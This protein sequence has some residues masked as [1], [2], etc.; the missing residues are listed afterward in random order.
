MQSI[1]SSRSK[2]EKASNNLRK[3]SSISLGDYTQNT[4]SNMINVRG[5][6]FMT[7]LSQKVQSNRGG[8]N[9]KILYE[10]TYKMAPNT[11]FPA[12]KIKEVVEGIL[13]RELKDIPYEA[14][15][16][17]Q[18]TSRISDIIKREVKDLDLDRYKLVCIV[19]IGQRGNQ[20]IKVGSRCLWDVR[21]DTFISAEYKNT[22]LFAI[23]TVF[24][25]Y[26]E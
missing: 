21:L 12:N 25:I 23:A 24:G 20:E 10:N 13:G 3:K 16:C 19:H 18:L 17:R 8:E 4:Q 7:P 5:P 1:S 11:A 26:F 6:L 22:S 9:T 2:E 15:N 14:E